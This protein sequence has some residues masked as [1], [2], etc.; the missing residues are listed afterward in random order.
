MSR[1]VVRPCSSSRSVVH[2]L[3]QPY[4]DCGEIEM[5]SL[6]RD[7]SVGNLA[8]MLRRNRDRSSAPHL[9]DPKAIARARRSVATG[10]AGTSRMR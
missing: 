10:V 6:L 8:S 5:E 4:Q 9:R 7:V 1:A 2:T 3:L